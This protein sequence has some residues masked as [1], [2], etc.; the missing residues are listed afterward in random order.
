MAG[1]W[2]TELEKGLK[3]EIDTEFIQLVIE[4]KRFEWLITGLILLNAVT[5]GLETNPDV[6]ARYGS[7]LHSLDQ[8]LLMIFTVELLLRLQ[9]YRGA[10][11][12]DAWS[13]FDSAI[14]IIAWLPATGSMSVLRALRILRVLRLISVVP[15]LRKVVSGLIAALPGMGSIMMLLCLVYYVFAVMGANLFAAEFPQWFGSLSQSA[16][17]LFQIMTLESWS[18][19]IVRPIMEVYPY[20][21]IYFIL[22]IVCTTFTVLNLFIGIIVS[23]MSAEGEAAAVEE[24]ELLKQDQQEILA[25][26]QLLR[27]EISRLNSIQ[28]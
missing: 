20:A 24:R 28:R 27:T 25:Q 8:L 18:M 3:K 6:V 1:T 13:L 2:I 14:I 11:F 16:Y 17:T 22:F 19:G 4:S 9:V 7:L 10:F 21:W 5:M 15:S 26:I 12:K 23:A